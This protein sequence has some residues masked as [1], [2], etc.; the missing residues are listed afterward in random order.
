MEQTVFES[1]GYSAE[2][3]DCGEELECWGV[4][5]LVDGFL[6]WDTESMC[7]ACGFA[8]AACGGDLPAELRGRLLSER[9]PARL[10]V[11]PSA[12]NAAIMRVLRAAL[13]LG[14]ADVRSVL[15]EVLE[16]AHSGTM[17]EMEFLARR[18]RASGIDAVAARP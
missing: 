8:V 18:L 4:Q 5:A 16:G 10:G 13:G 14:L 2:C 9:G 6:R 1:I 12:R 11:D 3:Q 15:N 7:S 17:P